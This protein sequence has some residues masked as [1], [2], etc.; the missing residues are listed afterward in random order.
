VDAGVRRAAR[1]E[2]RAAAARASDALLIASLV[3]PVGHLARRDAWRDGRYLLE[4]AAI[5]AAL[6]TA[7]KRFFHRPRPYAHHCDLPCGA[8]LDDEDARLSFYSGHAT[9]AFTAA[10]ATGTLAA[11]RG[12]PHVGRTWATG[13]ALAA[14]TSY[15]R[16]A[17]DRHYLT[18][19]LTGAAIGSAVGWG[20]VRLHRGEPQSPEARS[21][22]AEVARVPPLSMPLGASGRGWLHAGPTA[23]GFAASA[24]WSW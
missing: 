23:G 21:T 20:V 9:L 10:A 22:A 2:N 18:D 6:N 3:A 13:V 8:S 16:V 24:S 7:T 4:A 12:E 15:F 17:G 1:W 11:I 14:A 19:V 5:S